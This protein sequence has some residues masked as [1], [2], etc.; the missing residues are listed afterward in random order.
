[1]CDESQKP[2]RNQCE[3]EFSCPVAYNYWDAA[4]NRVPANEFDA[5]QLHML[6]RCKIALKYS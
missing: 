2:V 4:S 1:M 3:N 5:K 6:L